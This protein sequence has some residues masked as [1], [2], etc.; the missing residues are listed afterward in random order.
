MGLQNEVEI[1][2]TTA[3]PRQQYCIHAVPQPRFKRQAQHQYVRATKQG[4]ENNATAGFIA[5]IILSYLVVFNTCRPTSTITRTRTQ[6]HNAPPL[7][8]LPPVA[9]QNTGN[10][11]AFF[12]LGKVVGTAT[13][14]ARINRVEIFEALLVLAR[15]CVRSS[16]T[17][18][19][20]MVHGY[21]YL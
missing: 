15:E 14:P 19:E 18:Y 7:P 10:G 6:R 5:S 11:N 12:S 16:T 21:I 8:P 20:H 3:P 1:A 13:G 9:Y 17:C 2:P 4:P